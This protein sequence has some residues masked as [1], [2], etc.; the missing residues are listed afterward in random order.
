MQIRAEVGGAFPWASARGWEPGLTWVAFSSGTFYLVNLGQIRASTAKKKKK[1]GF[2]LRSVALRIRSENVDE[3]L[4]S[5]RR[6]ASRSYRCGREK[7]R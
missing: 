7:S 2:S 5:L 4:L 3:N 1:K 6:T